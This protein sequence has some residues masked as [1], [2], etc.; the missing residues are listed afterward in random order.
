MFTSVHYVGK[1]MNTA[2]AS[3]EPWKK[4]FGPVFVY[5]NSPSSSDLLWTDAKRQVSIWC[6]F[7]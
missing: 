3:S 4:M 2:Y 5:L 6:A 1:E 7:N